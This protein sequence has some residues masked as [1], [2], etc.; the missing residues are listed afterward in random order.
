VDA[1][2]AVEPVD[3]ED[4][5]LVGG[6]AEVERRRRRCEHLRLEAGGVAQAA[7]HDRR[8]RE[9]LASLA[10]RDSVELEHL[11]PNRAVLRRLGELSELGA[12]EVPGLPKLV[13]QPD[14][15]ARMPNDVRRKL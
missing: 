6:A 12:I 11:A 4:E 10:E 9:D 7:G 1:L 3:R 15:L 14:D 5:V 2:R 8:R 13:Q